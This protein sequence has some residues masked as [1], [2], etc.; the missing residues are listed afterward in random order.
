MGARRPEPEDRPLSPASLRRRFGESRRLIVEIDED[1]HRRPIAFWD[2]HGR[3]T[4]S[5][6]SRGEQRRLYAER[7]RAAA[8]AEGYIVL[9]VPWER[10]P[11]P[12]KRNRD[13]DKELLRRLVVKARVV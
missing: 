1:Q 6:V 9:E 8:R 10:R 5:G 13:A 3:L 7:K 11:S 12:G 2:K 4:V